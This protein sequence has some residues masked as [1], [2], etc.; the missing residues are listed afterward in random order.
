MNNMRTSDNS[1]RGPLQCQK[2][3]DNELTKL[4][5]NLL[6]SQR[7]WGW[8]GGLRKEACVKQKSVEKFETSFMR[9][10]GEKT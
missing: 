4:S 3:E 10:L 9:I 7:N 6:P 1:Q 5:F 2:S 8:G